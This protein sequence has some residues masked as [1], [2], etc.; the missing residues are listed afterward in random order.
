MIKIVDKGKCSGCGACY[1]ACPKNCISMIEDEE[2]FLYP[3]VDEDKCIDCGLCKRVCPLD[4]KNNIK[5]GVVHS[6]II[7]HKDDEILKQSTSG[8]GFTPIAEYVINHGGVVFGV[9]MDN[10]FFVKH[11]K[12]ENAN[13]LIKFR[14]SKYVQSFVGDTF[15]EA[16]KELENGRFVC[17]SGTPCQ[18]QGLKNYLRRDYENLVTVDV[19]CRGVPSPGVW[20]RYSDYLRSKGTIKEIVFRD[21]ALGYQYS[22]MKVEY[23]DGRVE[24]NGIESDQWLRMFFSGMILRPSCPTCSFRS[25]NRCSD[26]TIWDCFNVSDITKALDE[27][28]GAT[29][30]LIHTEKGLKLFDDIKNSFNI[31]EA[32]VGV[33]S[34]GIDGTA[35]QNRRKSEFINDFHKIDMTHLLSKWFPMNFKVIAKKKARRI[36]N[37]CGIDGFVKKIKRKIKRRFYE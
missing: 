27:T 10:D 30:M 26:F 18:I 24:R 17:F 32:P 25:I 37:K 5:N 12:V 7:Q 11:I 29:R 31:I 35:L 1:N 2:G 14:S 22:T 19:V 33:V 21:K 34:L 15:K 3:Q 13:E 9:Q 16:K 6:C 23:E 8:G 28:K 36:L 4:E 20:K